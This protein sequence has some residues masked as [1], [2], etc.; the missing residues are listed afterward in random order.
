L[1]ER[2][3]DVDHVIPF[4]LWGNND[5]WN[6]LPAHPEVNAQKSDMLPSRGLLSD[7]EEVITENWSL[8]RDAM[9][10]AFALQASNLLGSTMPVSGRWQQGLYARLREAVEV[11]ALQRGVGRWQPTA[12]SLEPKSSAHTQSAD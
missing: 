2:R 9:P 11:T 5:L 4:S 7:R 12:R 3:F 10:T 6:L 1:S 8:L